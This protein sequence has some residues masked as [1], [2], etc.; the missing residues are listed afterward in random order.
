[1]DLFDGAWRDRPPP[2]YFAGSAVDGQGGELPVRLVELGQENAPFPNDR[3][4]ESNPDGRLPSN[5]LAGTKLN[6][7]LSGAEA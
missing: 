4:R 6:R 2:Q 3:R 5:F 7:R 1:V